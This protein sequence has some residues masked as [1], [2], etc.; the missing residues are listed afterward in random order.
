MSNELIE[1]VQLLPASLRQELLLL[2]IREELLARKVYNGMYAIGFSTTEY[3]SLNG[4]IISLM[5]HS[6]H[7]DEMF[8]QIDALLDYYSDQYRTGGV[9]IGNCTDACY[10][11]ILKSGGK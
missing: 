7:D 3:F 2:L 10:E 8:N 5:G 4:I 9:P 6:L 11:A 1:A